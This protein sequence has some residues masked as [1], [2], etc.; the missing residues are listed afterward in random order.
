MHWYKWYKSEMARQY[1]IGDYH[2]AG[3]DCVTNIYITFSGFLV[4]SKQ[5]HNSN[6]TTPILRYVTL[7]LEVPVIW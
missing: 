5:T 3:F 4:H 1:A 7:E 2:R 6:F